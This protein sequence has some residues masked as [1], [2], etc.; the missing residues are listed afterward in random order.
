MPSYGLKI[1]KEGFDIGT[2]SIQNQ[3]LNSDF[4]TFK[5]QREG[6]GTANVTSLGTTISVSATDTFSSNTFPA[7]LAFMKIGTTE[8]WYAPYKAE[9]D[10]GN[11]IRMDLYLDPNHLRINADITATGGNTLITVYFY[12][13][14]EP[15]VNI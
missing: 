7:F 2:A 1:A 12:E 11:N 3:A 8:K 6:I 9:L 4:N 10:S 14:I 13:L 15:S 5:I